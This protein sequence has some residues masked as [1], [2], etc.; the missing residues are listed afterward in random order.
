[1]G[2]LHLSS[3]RGDAHSLLHG[4]AH[5]CSK[6]T[7]QRIGGHPGGQLRLGPLVLLPCFDVMKSK[8]NAVSDVKTNGQFALV[9]KSVD[10][11][12]VTVPAITKLTDANTHN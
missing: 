5:V 6:D 11:G 12:L 3:A 2:S 4:D 7:T 10:R 8:T 9:S 1:M